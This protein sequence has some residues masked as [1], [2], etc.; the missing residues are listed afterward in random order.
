MTDLA[1][2]TLPQTMV[3]KDD[4]RAAIDLWL[5]SRNCSATR[6]AYATAL[7]DLLISTNRLPWEVTRTDVLRWVQTLGGRGLEPATIKNRLAGVSSFFHFT[8]EEYLVPAG[9][10]ATEIPLHNNNPA[11]GKKL[12]PK[13]ELYGNATW[14][15][16]D[17]CKALLRAIGQQTTRSKRDYALFLGYIFL[18]RRNTEWRVASWGDFERHGS[19]VQYRWNG[20]GKTNQLIDVPAPVWDA[21]VA[22]LTF[23]GR[24]EK[25]KPGE[26]IFTPLSNRRLP[27][28]SQV[29][30]TRAISA[31]EV[32]RVLKGYCRQAGLDASKVHPHSL[33]HTGA[34]LR[35]KAGD[36]PEQIQHFLGQANLAITA[37]YLDH[38]EDKS[39][40]SWGRV[41]DLLGLGEGPKPYTKGRK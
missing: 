35:R 9:P 22:Y 28:G 8:M 4:W 24:L 41:A 15:S 16:P 29:D 36:S 34:M 19:Q 32:G 2:I 40:Q 31:H 13:V 30:K 20:K 6:R 3:L 10:E 5:A 39:D 11:A 33:R 18:A 1:V 21:V 26:A 25:I 23:T 37:V 12:R 17:E 7:Q 38:L 27:N 14:L